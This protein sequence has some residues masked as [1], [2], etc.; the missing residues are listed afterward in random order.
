MKGLFS[1]VVKQLNPALGG[2]HFREVFGSCFPEFGN[3]VG[4]F[5]ELGAA[6]VV[7][8]RA[9]TIADPCAMSS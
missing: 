5:R 3:Q 1:G 9:A 2:K 8:A 6:T 4:A 7:T